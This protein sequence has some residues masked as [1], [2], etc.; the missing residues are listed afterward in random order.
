MG[1]KQ[2]RKTKQYKMQQDQEE[3]WHNTDD[4]NDRHRYTVTIKSFN[5]KSTRSVIITKLETSCRQRE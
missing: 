1:G 4:E 2:Y 3:N 5:F